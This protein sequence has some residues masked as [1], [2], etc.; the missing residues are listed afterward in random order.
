MKILITDSER[1]AFLWKDGEAL[2]PLPCP[3]ECPYCPAASR[4]RL[5]LCCRKNRD[6]WCLSRRTLQTE[7]VFPAPPALAAACPSPCG[8]YLYLLSTEADAVQTVSL[9]T[10]E[11]CYAAPA[12][13]F[14]RSMKLHPSGRLL[15]CAGGAVNEACLL[16]APGLTLRHI[17][18][19]KNPCFGADFW[20]EGVVLLCAVEGENLQTA[21]PGGPAPGRFSVCRGSPERCASA[22]T[23][24]ARCSAPRTG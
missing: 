9:E 17:F 6:C 21:G 14:P 5:F 12:G 3:A 24:S 13:V 15:L 1:G 10:G 16:N 23:G 8:K 2:R 19:P 22:R 7:R 18:Y 20:R 11:L 4:E